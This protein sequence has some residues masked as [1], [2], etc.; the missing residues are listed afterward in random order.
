MTSCQFITLLFGTVP[1][2]MSGC[3][4][5]ANQQA[6][7]TTATQLYKSISEKDWDGAIG[8]YAPEFFQKM[9]KEQ[10]RDVLANVSKKLGDYKD[11]QLQ[12]WNYRSYVGTGGNQQTTTLT[13]QVQY[14][15]GEAT[16]TLTFLGNEVPLKIAGHQINSPQLLLPDK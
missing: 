10:W 6:A 1:L 5:S 8:L 14:L 12:N 4:M 13:F 9:P 3:G 15:N 7:E 2:L 16:E 11:R